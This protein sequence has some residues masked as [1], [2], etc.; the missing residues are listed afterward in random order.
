MKMIRYQ[1]I[2]CKAVLESPSHMQGQ[3]DKCGTCGQTN[4]VPGSSTFK[5][6][7]GSG[8]A[9][10]AFLALPAVMLVGVATVPMPA[11]INASPMA[12]LFSPTGLGMMI[13]MT[14]PFL[15][16]FLLGLT[17]MARGKRATAKV[18]MFGAIIGYLFFSIAVLIRITR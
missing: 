15:P 18:S 13:G 14:I 4:R 8:W 10:C 11:H 5:G 2:G 1:C 3:A 7:G 6:D 17:G 9:G 12:L 16:S